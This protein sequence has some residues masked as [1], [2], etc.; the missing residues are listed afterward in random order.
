MKTVIIEYKYYEDQDPNPGICEDYMSNFGAKRI[1]ITNHSNHI[2]NSTDTVFLNHTNQGKDIGAK[3]LGI[4]YLISTNTDVDNLIL[5]HDKK[6]PH[7]PLGNYW[8]Q[9]LTSVFK[10]PN[11]NFSN[12]EI[13]KSNTG[14]VCSSTYI[15]A[16]YNKATKQ[17]DSAN[18]E[19]LKLLMQQ[20]NI[21]PPMPYLYVA[22]TIMFCKWEPL[23][24]FFTNFSALDIRATLEKGNVQDIGIGTRTH[25]W[26][27]FFSWI[28]TSQGFSIKGI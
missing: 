24:K 5:L 10:S 14:I 4:D 20:Y 7:S 12:Q 17:F 27:R 15:K 23:K 3:L 8:Y 26:E 9:E 2:S 1:V 22:G 18:G 6:S 25:A 21:V 19:I 28:I 13:A 11:V 16:E